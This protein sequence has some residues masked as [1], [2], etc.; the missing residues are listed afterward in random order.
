MVNLTK[1]GSCLCQHFFVYVPDAPVTR[2]VTGEDGKGNPSIPEEKSR[3]LHTAVE[4][5]ANNLLIQ[6]PTTTGNIFHTIL[7]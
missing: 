4:N 7:S 5:V 6:P 1:C 3:A 2:A